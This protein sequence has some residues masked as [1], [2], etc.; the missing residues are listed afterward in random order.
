P[1]VREVDN[2]EE[3]TLAGRG[4]SPTVRAIGRGRLQPYGPRPRRP[5]IGPALPRT[6]VVR[7][8]APTS[9]GTGPAPTTTLIGG[10][11]GVAVGEGTVFSGTYGAMRGYR[12]AVSASTAYGVAPIPSGPVHTSWARPL[13]FFTPPA[14]ARRTPAPAR[15]RQQRRGGRAAVVHAGVVAPE[16]PARGVPGGRQLVVRIR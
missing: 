16:V 5:G 13:L 4:E 6:S 14:A 3:R 2:L 8:V 11:T 12:S 10:T 1:R 15:R 7:G 9:A